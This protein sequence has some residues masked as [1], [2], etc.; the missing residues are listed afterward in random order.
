MEPNINLENSWSDIQDDLDFSIVPKQKQLLESSGSTLSFE[1]L[2][3]SSTSKNFMLHNTDNQLSISEIMSI[4]YKQNNL[5]ELEILKNQCYVSSQL[6][7]FVS[8]YKDKSENLE[9]TLHLSKL[10][11]L[12]ETSQYLAKKKNL[13]EVKLKKK[14]TML[15]RNSYEF[16]NLGFKCTN[17]NCKHK[18]FV[19]NYLNN[20]ISELIKYLHFSQNNHVT[21][22]VYISVNTI[23]FVFNHMYDELYNT[24]NNNTQKL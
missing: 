17:P 20:D 2:K 15:Q 10:V 3:G 23:N 21:K 9:M 16:C 6:K 7:K 18:H 11:W 1:T 22:E 13:K 24:L 12:L 4:D 19:Y 5:S 8:S 14:Q